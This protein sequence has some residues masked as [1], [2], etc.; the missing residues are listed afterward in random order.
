MRIRIWS[1]SVTDDFVV[2][3]GQHDSKCNVGCQWTWDV[4]HILVRLH[5]AKHQNLTLGLCI[6]KNEV[7]RGRQL[8][9]SIEAQNKPIQLLL[10]SRLSVYKQPNFS[11]ILTDFIQFF[12]TLLLRFDGSTLQI[13]VIVL[14]LDHINSDR[15]WI[16]IGKLTLINDTG[17]KLSNILFVFTAC[18]VTLRIQTL[19]EDV[20]ATTNKIGPDLT[21]VFVI[22]NVNL[23]L[24]SWDV[25]VR[26]CVCSF[27]L[28]TQNV[29]VRFLISQ[30]VFRPEPV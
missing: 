18:L 14:G 27:L 25:I 5:F 24:T 16:W 13:V 6:L 20:K 1:H 30:V 12:K 7:L 23:F 15:F 19:V 10:V 2:H 22:L 4:K 29:D 8:H 26:S 9:P 21:H 3:F 17:Q 28:C 11:L